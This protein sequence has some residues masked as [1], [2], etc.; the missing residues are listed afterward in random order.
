M[1]EKVGKR[2]AWLN[3]NLLVKLESKRGKCVG[4]EAGVGSLGIV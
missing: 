4:K 3:G 2:W 1:S